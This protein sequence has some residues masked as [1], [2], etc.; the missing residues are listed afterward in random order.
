MN[1]HYCRKK[2]HAKQIVEL[3]LMT[4]IAIVVFKTNKLISLLLIQHNNIIDTKR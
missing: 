3:I 4:R 1:N 2:N